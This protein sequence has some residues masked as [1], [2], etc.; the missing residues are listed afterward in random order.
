MADE[1]APLGPP[2]YMGQLKARLREAERKL[3]R[4]REIA[5]I[6]NR[7]DDGYR[8]GKVRELVEGIREGIGGTTEG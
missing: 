6:I 5:R 7:E 1:E 4:A 2:Y 3:A 8:I